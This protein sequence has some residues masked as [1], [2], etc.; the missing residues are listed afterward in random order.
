MNV[1]FLLLFF[2]EKWNHIEMIIVSIGFTSVTVFT[3]T[4]VC[5]AYCFVLFAVCYNNVYNEIE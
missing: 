4:F 1:V 2:A 5:W 3:N